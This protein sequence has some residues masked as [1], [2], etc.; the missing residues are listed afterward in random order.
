MT[1]RI[2]L[3]YTVWDTETTIKASYKRKANPFDPE[4]FI[5]MQG[6]RRNDPNR[7]ANAPAN[8]GIVGEYFGKGRR[9]SNYFTKLLAGTKLLVGANIKF[10]V[11]HVLNDP[12]PA[13]ARANYLAWMEWVAGGGNVWD[14]Q[15]AEYQ[16]NGMTQADHML[17]LDEMAP[18]YG[19]NL[20]N[21]EVKALWEAGI[22][23]IDIDPDLLRNYLCGSWAGPMW[24]EGDIG[25]TELV[26]LG[27]YERAKA[28]GQV[29]SILMNMGSLLCSIEMEHNGMAVDKQAGLALARDI[30]Q[31]IAELAVEVSQYL[32]EDL[33]FDFNWNSGPQ[34]SALIFGGTVKYKKWLPH[35]DD[36]GQMQ[37]A[38]MD[39]D[40]YIMVDGSTV[41]IDTFDDWFHNAAIEDDTSTSPWGPR[42]VY[43][44]G[45]NKGEYKTKKVKVP[46]PEKPKGAIQDVPYTFPGFTKPKQAW[47]TATEGVYS[48]G[49]EIIEL[50]GVRNIPFLKSLAKITALR[51]DLTTYYITTDPKK[52]EVGMLTLVQADGII[53]HML[54]HTSTV[55]GRFS[56]SKPN[57]QNLPKGNKS[58]VKTL[59]ISRFK[60][61]KVIQ[62]DFSSLEVYVQAI[63]TKCLQLIEDLR[64]G[65][66]MHCVRVSQAENI[67]YEEAV[68]LCKGYLADGVFIDADG[69]WAYK[70]TKAKIFSFQRAY[71]A[72]AAKIAES[73]GMDIEEVEKLIQAEESRYPEMVLYYDDLNNTLDVNAQTTNLFVQHPE[74]P[75]MTCNLKKS[76]FRTPDNKLYVWMQS[77]A[78]K[79][80]AQRPA[81]KGGKTTS[82]SP[83]EVK[84]YPV[85]GTGGEWAKAAMWLAVREFY[86]LNVFHYKALLVNQ[87]HDALYVDA[88]DSVALQ[89]AAVL[90]ACMEEAS[91]FM[92]WYFGWEVPVPVPSE[93]TWGTSM[94]DE[95]KLPDG[96]ADLVKEH[97]KV[98]R[99]LYMN[100]YQPIYGFNTKENNIGN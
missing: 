98:V 68:K 11:L 83:T 1:D 44:G 40:A 79:W 39:A 71:G 48:T 33:P 75:G 81:S 88:D 90:H 8:D 92:E 65:L 22:D 76:Y 77:P 23:T 45:K 46:N 52:G 20:K 49:A 18:R 64:Q 14:I 30:E 57:L 12:D 38:M 89:A 53:H 17:S 91:V 66:D 100:N 35:L 27:Q 73:T 7:A 10:D 4:N 6:Y 26:W 86:R 19:G 60:N 87:V 25:N 56:S 62:S 59:F 5:V 43:A 67:S 55:T 58:K 21:D 69:D 50:L 78:P 3:P 93:T 28:C 99:A 13:L 42:A 34:K 36:Q 2:K 85:Q 74:I 29:K 9:P 80:L 84:N 37:Y 70:R 63:L 51:K 97:R 24:E 94:M 47:A 32:P 31:E 16:L 41:T 54:N 96:F 95:G 61:G 15:L 82:F 72:G